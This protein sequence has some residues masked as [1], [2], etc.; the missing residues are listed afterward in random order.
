MKLTAISIVCISLLSGCGALAPQKAAL[1]DS[2]TLKSDAELI[3]M[4]AN[5][6]TIDI[7]ENGEKSKY[8]VCSEPMP[9]IAMSNVL[10]L[11]LE[12]SQN[13]T[14]KTSTVTGADSASAEAAQ[15]IGVKGSGEAAATALELAGRTQVVLLAREFLY[16][17][18]VA[19]ANGWLDDEKFNDSQVRIID[20]ISDMISLEKEQAKASA[21]KAEAQAAAV[22]L[23][24]DKKA[25]ADVAA[26][27]KSEKNKYCMQKY[28][29]CRAN[30]KD[31][32]GVSACRESLT[33]C[34]Q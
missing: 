17:N 10:K 4:P 15:S 7:R 2:R 31:E 9:D 3:T 26:A 16:R 34:S 14:G 24:L 21:A 27:V 23:V 28:D 33:N 30:A 12:A 8:I 19:R 6:R 5:L 18:C 32:K 13:A 1:L 22:K 29:D 11:A 25:I 20:Q